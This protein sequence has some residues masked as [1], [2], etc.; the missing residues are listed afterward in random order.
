MPVN[1]CVYVCAACLKKVCNSVCCLQGKIGLFICVGIS[2]VLNLT[3]FW[4]ER[5]E[6][7]KGMTLLILQK[8]RL[9]G[10]NREC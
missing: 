6:V 9:G 7:R 5:E 1:I 8:H 10:E 4:Q 2:Y 3:Y